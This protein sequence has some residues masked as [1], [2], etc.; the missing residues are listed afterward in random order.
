M[1]VTKETLEILNNFSR[2]NKNFLFT[3]GSTL[4]TMDDAK[5]MLVEA[6]IT[7]KIPSRAGIGD[8]SKLLICIKSLNDC[9]L[10]FNDNAV[11]V[12]NDNSEAIFG[13][14]PEENISRAK[15]EIV[16]TSSGI[17]F[18][19]RWSVLS[20]AVRYSNL[21]G[22]KVNPTSNTKSFDTAYF[23]GDGEFVSIQI[24]ESKN[25]RNDTLKIS[26]G[27]SDRKFQF[28]LKTS[29]LVLVEDDYLCEVSINK[30]IRF[31]GKNKPIKYYLSTLDCIVED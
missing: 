8:L 4:Q 6:S 23:F 28:S 25:V 14:L 3:E 17:T 7:E 12:A 21:M 13:L 18:D 20:E 5:S 29:N 2:I 30:L 1:K 11:K 24:Q 10:F 16:F 22:V 15:K 31:T 9:E 27:K 19:L 26:L